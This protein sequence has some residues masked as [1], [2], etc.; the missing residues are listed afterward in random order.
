MSAAATVT[1][2]AGAGV[3]GSDR[4]EITWPNNSIQKEWLEVIVK[5]NDTLGGSDTNT[6]LAASNVFFY[7]SAVADDGNTPDDATTFRTDSNDE[8]DARNNPKTLVAN[9]PDHEHLRL[10]P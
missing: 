8:I 4:V 9:I 3:G 6:G 2:R 1:T 5:G 10:Q 7:G